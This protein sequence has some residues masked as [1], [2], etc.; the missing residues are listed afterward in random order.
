MGADMARDRKYKNAR[1]KT[2]W[3]WRQ[4]LEGCSLNQGA[5]LRVIKRERDG[6]DLPLELLNRTKP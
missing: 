3:K 5:F 1:K 6:S 2:T 4:N